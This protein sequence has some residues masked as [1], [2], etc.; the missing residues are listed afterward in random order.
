MA[1]L[2][3]L[4]SWFQFPTK[5]GMKSPNY[6]YQVTIC[7]T[8]MEK[9]SSFQ[10]LLDLIMTNKNATTTRRSSSCSEAFFFWLAARHRAAKILKPSWRKKKTH[11]P[12]EQLPYIPGSLKEISFQ[13]RA[14][15]SLK[16]F[17]CYLVASH[18]PPR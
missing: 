4:H 7:C 14:Q 5:I 3:T 11:T 2:G 16:K 6:R 9:I 12:R 17:N 8:K 13:T 10:S 15:S 18:N 1:R